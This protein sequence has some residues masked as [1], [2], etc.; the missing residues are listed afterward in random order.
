MDFLFGE[1]G[2][3][4]DRS[5]VLLSEWPPWVQAL[6][7]G[8]AVVVIGLT[9]YNYRHLRPLYRRIGMVTLRTLIV[10]GLLTIF[11][12]PA[13]LEENVA[14]SRNHVVVLLDESESMGLPHGEQTRQQLLHGFVTGNAAL[15]ETIQK[16]NA[17]SF[18]GFS[19]GPRELPDVDAD[20]ETVT[21][22][23]GATGSETR[24][25]A[26]L[27]EIRTRYRNRDIGGILVVS[28]GIDTG[29]AGRR[30]GLSPAQA[31]GIRDL[32]APVYAFTTAGDARLKDIAIDSVAY[33]NFA[34][35]M[36]A[37][38]LEAVVSVH[39]YDD[40]TL[41]VRLTEDGQEVASQTITLTPGKKA[42]EVPFEFV[43]R[44]LGKHVYGIDVDHRLDEVYAA[45]N[46]EQVVINVIRDKI[47]VLQIVGQPSWDE[48]FLRGLLKSDPNVDLISF[49]ILVNTSNV[50]P[51]YPGET[52]LIPF[53]ARELFEE[54]LG[55]FDLAIFQNFNYGPF[56]TRKYLPAIAQYV[57]EGGAFL[58]VGGPLSFSAG[59]YYGTPITDI[60]P[61]DIP[62]EP[63]GVGI[64][65]MS[66]NGKEMGRILDTETFRAQLSPAGK[67]HP[68]TRLQLDP[69]A[70]EATW[71]QLEELEGANIVRWAKEDAVVLVEHPKLRDE[72][73]QPMPVVAV[74]EV[75]KG[76]AMSV[77]TDSTW[78]WGFKAGNAGKDSRHYDSFWRNA[79]R[80]LIKDPELDLV[81]VRVIRQKVPVGEA[82][83][84]T[85][86]VFEPDYQ[87][88]ADQA[89]DVVV[90]QRRAGEG[91]GQ[92]EE[93][94]RVSDKRTDGDGKLLLDI[95]LVK[96]GVYEV[97][98]SARVVSERTETGRDLF[99]ATDLKAE[100]ATV[101]GDRR[102]LEAIATE[103][104]GRVWPIE[105][106]GPPLEL[107]DPKVTKIASRRHRE[108]WNVPFVL[109]ILILLFGA[110]W[111][112]R[113]RFGYL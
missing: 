25:I 74:N 6:V 108:L 88:A 20:P 26:A 91:T 1:S 18:Y 42:Y 107:R 41:D 14:R 105:T 100:M 66:P 39:G 28:D 17:L 10:L 86:E 21:E 9:V 89:V 32:E 4:T 27:Q 67:Y 62:R 34:F 111:W 47:R 44:K 24:I 81:R 106:V 8:I 94:L 85:I 92:G 58:M 97:E 71:G 22:H 31:L 98:A 110:E 51:T 38:A 15:W 102:V 68:I 59:R 30:G 50:R 93:I 78:H 113:R 73:G 109:L 23:V 75:G 53:P 52:A 43:P 69:A 37:S 103:S 56:K 54:E 46:S 48:R 13:F 101:V 65:P 87:P 45:N 11:Y 12:Q 63:F 76:R 2:P 57:K 60:L 55:G 83:Q 35:W 104:G 79:I 61:V 95:P 84:A 82:A 5:L 70:N 33:S 77:M 7:I 80:W 19:A 112:L 36:N 99:V 16:D 64:H 3:Y 29:A 49:F 40:G 96:A 90:R 72:R